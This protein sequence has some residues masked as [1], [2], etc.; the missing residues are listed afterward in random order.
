M[1][2]SKLE[3][4]PDN[5]DIAIND[6]LLLCN[7]IQDLHC[8]KS[9][10]QP[11]WSVCVNK[12]NSC[13]ITVKNE[14]KN[15]EGF[16]EMFTDFHKRYGDKYDKSILTQATDEEDYVTVNDDF[17]RDK[18][19]YPAPGK[20][21]PHSKGVSSTRRGSSWGKKVVLKGP[22]IYYTYEDEKAVGVC[23][24]IGE[25]YRVTIA[26]FD[27]MEKNGDDDADIRSLSAR[28]LLTFFKL[29]DVSCEEKCNPSIKENI[30]LLEEAVSEVTIGETKS[31]SG[32]PFGM[33]KDVFKKIL[34]SLTKGGKDSILPKEAQAAL[35]SVMEGDTLDEVGS[36]FSEISG[37][38]EKGAAEAGKEG[39]GKSIGKMMG[40]ISETLQS[41]SV[42][43]KIENITNKL[44]QF[45]NGG[46][47]APP[48]A[49]LK[50]TE[51]TVDNDAG[52]QE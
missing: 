21:K 52:D 13:Y 27:E 44:S 11:H 19:L 33:L 10:Q 32:G 16:R 26:M 47:L 29:I 25:I 35:N 5:L 15:S 18:E 3:E 38:I 41:E 8:A 28:L 31:S 36:M 9:K 2:D 12:L 6:L 7:E 14:V 37:N 42:V 45:A 48:T 40:T 49:I 20:N 17:F 23:I 39:G 43:S 30:F 24:P 1:A 51:S 46:I 34:P 4:N 22:V 50:P